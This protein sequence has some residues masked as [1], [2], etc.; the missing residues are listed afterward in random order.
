M[1]E[2]MSTVWKMIVES[3][4]LS[5]VGALLI[6]LAGWVFSLLCK[7]IL[8]SGLTKMQ[9]NRRLALCLPDNEPGMEQPIDAERL[10]AGIFFWF[11]FLMTILAAL[12]SLNLSEAAAPIKTFMNNVM[13]YLPCLI[14]GALLLFLAW[15]TAS[16]LKYLA[17]TAFTALHLD[18]K[19]EEH[20]DTKGEECKLSYSIATLLYWLVYLCF[21]P[22]ILSALKVEGITSALQAM[23][24]KIFTYLPN[25]V[26]AGAIAFFGL[27]CAGLLRKVAVK[28]VGGVNLDIFPMSRDGKP[29]FE[30]KNLANL[31]GIATYAV[32][33]IPVVVAALS[34]L[35][36][37][38][39]TNSVSTLF[40]KIL[41]AAGNLFGALLLLFAAYIAGKFVS[42]LVAQLLESFGFNRLFVSLGFSRE[43]SGSS[44]DGRTPATVVGQLTLCAIMLFAFIGALELMGFRQLSSLLRSFVPFAGR[45]VIATVVFLIGIYLANL[46]A[47]AIRDKGFESALFSLGLRVTILFFAGAVALHTADIGGPIVQTAF[48][49]ILG[50]LA[51]AA[52]L[53][54]GLGGRDIAARKLREWTEDSTKNADEKKED[55]K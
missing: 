43:D 47:S 11:L 52:A 18:E 21:A 54:F 55:K 38:A 32:I 17:L 26:A 1:R 14:A 44:H 2:F 33:A 30:Q 27:F 7:K 39:L 6:F 53:A 22:A 41:A 15:L 34:A 8:H 50:S 16:A 45:L 10:I 40:S 3:N 13:G 24:N 48:T 29:V 42:R 51:V 31:A 35:K 19:V 20:I 28:F 12:S 49:L 4:I 9:L 46:A 23:L 37:E 36:I 5:V 25:L